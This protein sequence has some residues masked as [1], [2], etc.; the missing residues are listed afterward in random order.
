MLVSKKGRRCGSFDIKQLYALCNPLERERGMV[1]P[2]EV[3]MSVSFG[4][5][6]GR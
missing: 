6:V 3:D 5:K 1:G 2:Y 4:R